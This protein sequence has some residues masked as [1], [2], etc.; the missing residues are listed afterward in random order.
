MSKED[1][2]KDLMVGLETS[3]EFH[4]DQLTSKRDILVAVIHWRLISRG[5]RCVGAGDQ[6]SPE[7]DRTPS[8]L[9]P[10]EWNKDGDQVNLRYTDELGTGN[11]KFLLAVTKAGSLIVFN[12][13]RMAD[14][15]VATRHEHHPRRRPTR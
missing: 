5:F 10:P 2:L 9:L 12:V 7:T 8:E 13:C 3:Y 11:R 6:F 4:K 15:K 14:E 1:A